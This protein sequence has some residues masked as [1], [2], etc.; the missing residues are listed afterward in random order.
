[1]RTSKIVFALTVCGLL[2]SGCSRVQLAEDRDGLYSQAVEASLQGNAPL[3]SRAAHHYLR[4][5]TEDDPRYD[6]A[7]RVLAENLKELD[8]SYAS[9]LY[10]FDIA[11][12]R[13]DA[14]MVEY[15]VVGLARI[16]ET[17]PHDKW[18]L[19]D[20][21]VAT[22]DITGLSGEAEAFV[23]YYQGLHSLQRG[24]WEW[25]LDLFDSIPDRSA[26]K[27]RARYVLAVSLLAAYDLGEAEEALEEIL[28]DFEGRLPEDI[29]NDIRRGLARIAFEIGD[30]ETALER[31]EDIRAIAPDDPQLLLEMAWTEYYLHNH[32]RS[33]GLLLA[34][35]APAFSRLI[36]PERFMLE[37]LKLQQ[38]CQFEPARTAA[39]RLGARYGDALDDMRRGVA[40]VDSDAL[41]SAARLREAATPIADFRLRLLREQQMVEGLSS[42]LGDSLSAELLEIYE[43]GIAEV[44]RRERE[45]LSGEME[46]LATE[47]LSAAEG[48][49]LILHEISVALLRGRVRADAAEVE[50]IFEVPRGGEQVYYQFTGEFWTDEIDDLIVPLEDRC[51]E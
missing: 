30:Y 34:L 44:D 17:Y 23:N 51:I 38:L 40:V 29:Y 16:I 15:A 7:S 2:W 5:G 22:A 49:Q 20:G 42:R 12:A 28:E 37:A 48:V 19:I 18:T 32:R 6:R 31:Y 50:A 47:L 41:R 36:A 8:L 46:A 21:F 43:R 1:M 26:Y 33:L 14:E 27:A 25:G 11:S 4:G 24:E 35:D 9:S 10:Y 13:R 39:V 3:A 45:V